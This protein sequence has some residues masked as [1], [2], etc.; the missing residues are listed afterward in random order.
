MKVTTKV[1]VA[2]IVSVYAGVLSILVYGL[3]G[4][5]VCFLLYWFSWYYLPALWGSDSQDDDQS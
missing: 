3:L 2:K 1:A 5:P 4:F